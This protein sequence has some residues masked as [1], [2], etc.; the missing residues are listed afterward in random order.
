MKKSITLILMIVFSLTVIN[1]EKKQADKANPII[2]IS[3][4]TSGLISQESTIKVV[5]HEKMISD[6][7][8]DR[9]ITNSPFDIS[10]SIK[11]KTKWANSRTLVFYPDTK[12]PDDQKYEVELDLEAIAETFYDYNTFSFQ[13]SIIKQNLSIRINELQAVSQTSL[14]EQILSGELITADKEDGIQ[15]EKILNAVQDNEDLEIKWT[16]AADRRKHQF[17]I[18]GIARQ[19][20][21]SQ[22]LL[23]WDGEAIDVE[24]TGRQEI[25][26]PALSS[27][28]ITDVKAIKDKAE[29]IEIVFSDPLM[30]EQNLRGL[31]RTKTPSDLRY[32]ID[33]N[34]TRVYNSAKWSGRV[35]LIIDPAVKNVMGYKLGKQGEYK[36]E[37]QDLKPRVKFV[38]KGVIIPTTNDAKLTIEAVNLRAVIVEAMQIYEQNIHQFFQQNRLPG[39]RE[40]YRVGNI[41]WQDTVDLGLTPDKVNQWNRYGLDLNPL[42]KNFPHGMYRLNIYFTKDLSEYDCDDDADDENDENNGYNW[43]EYHRNKDNPCHP[44]YYD[45]Y[46]NQDLQISRNIIISNIGILAKRGLDNQTMVLCTDLNTGMPLSG[47]EIELFN[48]QQK[49]I[50]EGKTDS[51]G[52]LNLDPSAKPFLVLARK[53]SQVGYLKIDDGSALTMSHFDVGG[54]QTTGKIKGFI[55]G[56]RDVWRPGDDIFLTFILFDPENTIPDTHPV[57]LDFYNARD[58]HIKTAI[59]TQSLNGF[60]HFKLNTHPDD[61]TGNWR[62]EIRIGGTIFEKQ[63]KIETIRPNRF[64]FELDLGPVAALQKGVIR[65]ELK[66]KWLHGAPAKNLKADIEMGLKSTKTVFKDYKRFVFDDPARVYEP[67]SFNIF[68][69]KLDEKG[70]QVFESRVNTYNVAPGMLHAYFRARVFEASGAFSTKQFKKPFH[71]YIQY[72]GMYLPGDDNRVE[73]DSSHTVQ[74]VLVDQNGK[75]VNSGDLEIKVHKIQWRW[76][77]ERNQQSLADYIEMEQY[78][79]IITKKVKVA[80]GKAEWQLKIDGPSWNRYLIRIRDIKHGHLTGKVVYAYSRGWR[81]LDQTEAREGITTL[82]LTTD[83]QEYTVGEE[84]SVTIP[85]SS[86]GRGIVSVESGSQ[87]LETHHITGL[88]EPLHFKLKATNQMT[89]NVYINVSYWQSHQEVNNDLPIRMY[90]VVPVKVYDPKTKI[91]PQIDVNDVLKP[92]SQ[93]VVSI[94]E[95]NGHEMTYTVAIVDEGLLNLTGFKTPDPWNHFYRRV[96]LGIK[97]WDL[98]DYV[99]GAY[100]GAWESLLAIGGGADVAIEGEKKADRFPPLV[101]YLGPFELEAGAK[102]THEFEI[103]QYVGSV[104]IMVVAAEKNAFGSVQKQV[105][106]KNPLM[107][108]GTMPRVLGPEEVVDLPVTVFAMEDKV[109]KVITKIEVSDNLKIQGENEK[110]IQFKEIGEQT[111]TFKIQAGDNKGIA[112]IDINAV[113][114]D[115]NA[116]YHIEL[117]IRQPNRP[118]TDV[119]QASLKSGESWDQEIKNSGVPGTNSGLLEIS[120]VPPLNLGRR[121][122]F[123]IRYPHGCI[124]QTTSAA[125]PQ[126]YLAKILKMTDHQQ[127]DIE[128]NVKSAISKLKSFQITNGGF[129]YWP[130][131]YDASGW[132]SNYAG[133]FLLEAK[134]LGYAVPE[135]MMGRWLKFQKNQALSW[136]TGPTRSML[137]QAYRLFTLALAGKPEL[138]AMNRLREQEKLPNTAKWRLA[139]AYY[140]AGQEGAANEIA[141]GSDLKT[142]NYRELTYTYGSGL[143]DKAMILEALCIIGKTEE[144]IELAEKISEEMCSH[145]WISTQTT[146]YSLIGLARYAGVSMGNIQMKFSYRWNEVNDQ[147]HESTNAVYQ[148]ELEPDQININK[149]ELSNEGETVLYPRLIMEGIPKIGEEKAAQNDLSINVKYLTITGKQMVPNQFEQGSDYIVDITVKNTGKQGRYDEIALSHLLPSGFEIQNTRMTDISQV[150]SD[151]FDYQ[152][153]RDDRIY[154]YFDL[155]QDEVKQYKVVVNASFTGRYY[156]P[157]ISVEAMYDATIH[158]R[159]PGRWIEITKPG[160]K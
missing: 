122:R 17:S 77:W 38:G 50:G 124:E 45:E 139:A 116:G 30:K 125:F 88:G 89:P 86:N 26:V 47:A 27:F 87:I 160:M 59:N 117:D 42:I 129:S 154:T 105:S 60:T 80:N 54:I 132:C 41:V 65:G 113:G 32:E 143:R 72:V 115:E 131:Y 152:D 128:K 79:P 55:Y 159:V 67:E 74:I 157:M 53:S 10:P 23:K 144:A 91:Y 85:T 83:K 82:N 11:G 145:K 111:I 94:N 75:P 81:G 150:K 118:V 133:H 4:H 127:K 5:F 33:L 18:M 134:K 107:V 70:N 148:T 68:E 100:G 8:T 24:E 36:L 149:M 22:V 64:D 69:G 90:G 15:I 76:W 108:L 95:K 6:D 98:Y 28:E 46:Y 135:L 114:V 104:R 7:E 12:L 52:M 31:I 123:L 48:F 136:V 39:D 84:I 49:I 25:R 130:G 57:R 155:K 103:P 121:L 21:D 137:I 78:D 40:L 16:H 110:Q 109:K 58:Q 126:L 43:R 35:D 156:L 120:R 140:L 93:A 66:A 138:G 71:P 106:V 20:T 51:E 153:I 14:K 147:L 96:A 119:Y 44:A 9:E 158:A 29:Y 101:I 97:T 34:K 112:S 146:A 37:F 151:N 62:V 99:S 19:S 2:L 142:Q 92:E 3:S 56:E 73:T 1:C 102:N 13:F 63:I 61:P 141:D